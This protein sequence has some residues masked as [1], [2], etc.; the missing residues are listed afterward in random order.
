MTL[1]EAIAERLKAASAAYYGGGEPLMS[2]MEFDIIE[3]RLRHLAPNHPVLAQIGSPVGN[4]GWPKV[5]HVIPMGSLGKAQ[6]PADM[7]AWA[8]SLPKGEYVVTDKCDGISIS[9]VYEGGLLVRAV[10]RGDGKVGEDITRNVRVMKG[11]PHEVQ[12]PW[13]FTV[14]G[15][16]VCTKADFAEHFAGESNPRNTA[17]GTAKR[18]SEW[19]KCRHLTVIAYNVHGTGQPSRTAELQ[20][21]KEHGF[22]TPTTFANVTDLPAIEAIMADYVDHWRAETPYL[23]DG[24][25]IELDATE[26]R[27]AAGTSPDGMVPRGA[28]AYKFAHEMAGTTLCDVVWQTGPTGRI[29]PV[30][31]FAP[32]PLAGANVSRA[33][34]HNPGYVEGL[35]GLAV[36]DQIRVSR[37]NDVIP[38]VECVLWRAGGTPLAPEIHACPA[39]GSPTQRSGAYLVC[40]NEETC[41]AQVLGEVKRWLSKTGVLHFGEAMV[42][43]AVE[44]DLVKS[45]GDLYRLD[46]ATLG[47]LEMDGRRIGGAADRAL[48]SLHEHKDLDVATF[49]GSLGIPLCGRRMVEMLVK[50]GF[51]TLEKLE[52]ATVNDLSMVDGFGLTKAVAFKKGWSA[53][54]PTMND[55]LAAGVTVQ[56]PTQPKISDNSLSN[57]SVCFTGVRDA[58]LEALIVS[59]GGTIKS[60]VAKGLTYLVCKD[61]QS[62]SG[63]AVKARSLGVMTL[64]LSEAHALFNHNT[65]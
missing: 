44:A 17:S 63:K 58:D 16:I 61:P 18:Q 23:I 7:A 52:A 60:G 51:D 30:A 22:E 49:V 32:V 14:R 50:A 62:T 57:V 2:D 37:R 53:R 48:A 19:Q 40:P 11:V 9:L 45:L 54:K 35:G 21:L 33:S 4:T 25:V 26:A 59:K 65:N 47:G 8:A 36:G 64:S 46:P 5:A 56:P 31:V 12:H 20:W 6:G 34:L 29:T 28:V 3:A 41:P 42:T 55:L 43:A 1:V 24:L 15:E 38:A 39:C 10:T 13:D 27:E